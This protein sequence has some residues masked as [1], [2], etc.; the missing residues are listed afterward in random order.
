[1][2]D[3]VPSDRLC[4]CE[5]H[6]HAI[7]HPWLHDIACPLYRKQGETLAS[8]EKRPDSIAGLWN[9]KVLLGARIDALLTPF[10]EKYQLSRD[11][12]TVECHYSGVMVRVT[13]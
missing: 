5:T 7:A 2:S 9:D 10:C 8:E 4:I 3:H 11:Q 6:G 1:M 12:V 13:L